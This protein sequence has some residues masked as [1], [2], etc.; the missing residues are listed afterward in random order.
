MTTPNIQQRIDDA[1]A[2]VQAT[3]AAALAAQLIVSQAEYDTLYNR[4]VSRYGVNAPL[5]WPLDGFAWDESHA[6]TPLDLTGYH[7][8][9]RDD[10]NTMSV[11]RKDGI[12]PW[13]AA[14]HASF[15][16]ASLGLQP[17]DYYDP[18]SIVDGALRITMRKLDATTTPPN[19]PNTN[20]WKGG[21][22]Q[23]VNEAGQGFAQ[24]GGYFEARMR[25][26]S[27]GQGDLSTA[28][29]AWPA[30]WLLTN[31]AVNPTTMTRMEFDIV[32]A[33]GSDPDGVHTT[34]HYK[35]AGTLAPGAY[36]DR[37]SKSNYVGLKSV[38]NLDGSLLFDDAVD[39]NPS[40]YHRQ[41]NPVRH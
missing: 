28:Q 1:W 39:V 3:D 12:G 14:V 34:L 40:L 22:I 13:Y 25:F 27:N 35:P 16:D 37:Q 21:Y 23:S 5:A 19:A 20:A 15:G 31:D 8:T 2:A 36:P 11:T 10:F 26:P 33:Y 17:G 38:K 29:G 4:I 7:E 41:S 6:G 24:G 32:E 9:F 18:F 30:F